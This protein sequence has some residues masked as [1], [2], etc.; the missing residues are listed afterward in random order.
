M[1]VDSGDS[2]VSNALALAG[3]GEGLGRA[4]VLGG[5]GGMGLPPVLVF[6]FGSA[7]FGGLVFVF[8]ASL[9]SS[10]SR[11]SEAFPTGSFAFPCSA[12]IA[13]A[14]RV[15]PVFAFAAVILDEAGAIDKSVRLLSREP[16]RR[17]IPASS[18]RAAGP[19]RRVT[20]AN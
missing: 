4:I 9:G 13:D 14:G 2:I 18:F 15:G 8:G 10:C 3:G 1:T 5:G 7:A 17:M 6:G 11:L 19:W 12:F 16:L 20:V